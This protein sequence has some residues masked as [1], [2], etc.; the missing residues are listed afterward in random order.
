VAVTAIE[1]V[2]ALA[3]AVGRDLGTSPWFEVTQATVDAFARAVAT[4]A[5]A[6]VPA[7]TTDLA[8]PYLIMSLSNFFLPQILEVT[9][10][11][12]G[13]NYGTGEVRFPAPVPV[14]SRVRARADLVRADPVDGGVQ[15]TILITIEVE[16]RAESACVIEALSRWLV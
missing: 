4:G 16:G 14:G 8:P 9:G 11:S 7:T 2:E 5:T 12:A 15:T 3:A 10:I 1:G 6:A 13:V